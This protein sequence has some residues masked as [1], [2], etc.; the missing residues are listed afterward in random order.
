MDTIFEL[1]GFAHVDPWIHRTTKD[2]VA[3]V[4]VAHLCVVCEELEIKTVGEFNL[5]LFV[6]K[7]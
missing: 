2:P 6:L 1:L 4:E 7:N 3:T 5:F